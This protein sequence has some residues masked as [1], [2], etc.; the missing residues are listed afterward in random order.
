MTQLAT[1][2][3]LGFMAYMMWSDVRRREGQPISWVPLFWMFLAGSRWI[4]SWFSLGSPMSVDDYSEGSP[5]DRAVFMGLIAWGMIVLAKR[6]IT[7]STLIAD[8]MWLGAYLLFTV[9]SIF[10]SDEPYLSTKR[11]IKDLGNPV[12]ALVMLTEPRRPLEAVGITLRRLAILLLPL[13]VLF[14][15]YYP[16]LGRA[17]RP[18]GSPMYTGVGHQKNDLGLMCL[19]TGIYFFWKLLQ[20][21]RGQEVAEPVNTWDFAL[22]AMLLWLLRVSDS[23]TS[24]ACLVAVVLCLL[25]AR[26]PPLAFRVSRVVPVLAGAVL[27]AVALESTFH[28][29]DTALALLGRDPSLTN[30]TDLWAVVRSF[31]TNP[32]VGAGFMSFWSGPRMTAIWAAVGNGVVQAHNGYLEQYLNLGYLGVAMIV[33]IMLS[34]LVTMWRSPETEGSGVLLRLCCLLAAALYNYTEAA[35][36][37][38]NNMWVLF[39]VAC[40]TVRPDALGVA[41]VPTV[42][43]TVAV[44]RRAAAVSGW[45]HPADERAS[46]GAP[47]GATPRLLRG[48]A[49]LV[50]GG[51][52][53]HDPTA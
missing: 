48:H 15:R 14:I 13:S 30:R 1:I 49:R 47:T 31:E 34:A 23:Q 40:I 41:G 39:L 37:G 46:S 50:S 29:K 45:A 27:C 6:P 53:A 2:A 11:W 26:L 19:V 9:G 7:V 33:A 25:L 8:N 42:P 3:C 28:L 20:K 36:Y 10:W 21:R 16:Q 44:R 38:I 35:F 5:V 12:M 17:Y 24:L 32:Y 43:D 52:P 51:R 18:D 22:I 4:S